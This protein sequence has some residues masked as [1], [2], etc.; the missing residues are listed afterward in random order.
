MTLFSRE[1][2]SFTRSTRPELSRKS[3]E[4]ER[5]NTHIQLLYSNSLASIVFVPGLGANPEESWKSESTGFN[6]TTDGLVRDFP[7]ARILLYMY[8]SAWT[9]SLK[10]KQFM[11]A[12]AMTLLNGLRSKREVSI[13]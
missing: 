4:F 3:S 5:D 2:R 12:I 11:G 1:S 8:E 13:S 10:V 7:R 9:G 6:W